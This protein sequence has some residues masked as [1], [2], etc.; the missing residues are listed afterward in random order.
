MAGG[1]GCTPSPLVKP[2]HP[3]EIKIHHFATMKQAYI[4]IH[5][6][7]QIKH[8]SIGKKNPPNSLS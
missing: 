4:Q 5:L 7:L 6:N 8:S 2:P 1:G 3:S